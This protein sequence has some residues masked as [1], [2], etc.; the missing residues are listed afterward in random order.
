MMMLD[1]LMFVP[2]LFLTGLGGILAVMAHFLSG[3]QMKSLS[4]GKFDNKV[5]KSRLQLCKICNTTHCM[6]CMISDIGESIRH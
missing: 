3:S 6:E 2:F 4:D 1:A 5:C